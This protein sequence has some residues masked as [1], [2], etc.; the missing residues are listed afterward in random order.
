MDPVQ[1]LLDRFVTDAAT[2]RARSAALRG[3]PPS[4]GPDAAT[5]AKMAEACDRVVSLI[6][7]L[8]A[9][10]P[11]GIMLQSLATLTLPLEEL[12]RK[13]ADVPAVRAVYAGAATRIRE[14]LEA[15]ASAARLR[16]QP[17]ADRRSSS[18]P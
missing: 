11:P 12:S 18:E 3:A 6:R 13:Q 14:L 17:I 2:L 1:Y 4:A 15:E 5:S 8:P 7:S 9:H 16:D 10:E